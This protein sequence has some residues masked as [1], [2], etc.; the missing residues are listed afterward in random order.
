MIVPLKF[1]KCLSDET[2]LKS[3]LLV[4][5]FN[6][7]CVCDLA[8]ALRLSQPKI[9]RHLAELRVQGLLIGER[10]GKWVYYQLNPGLPAW[11]LKVLKQTAEA[12]ADLLKAEIEFL[13]LES[14]RC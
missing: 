3:V 2:R 6:Q 7:L 4:R 5:H 10:R 11:L 9:S 12:D 14:E 1:Y 13:N 8:A